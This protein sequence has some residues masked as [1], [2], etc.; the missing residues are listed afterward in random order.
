[1]KFILTRH[2]ETDWNREGR[3]QG[4]SDTHLNE[5]GWFQ[6]EELAEK[7]KGFEIKKI[8]SSDLKR[9]I[10]TSSM[11][12]KYLNV[13]VQTDPRIRECA[14]GK[15]EG[16]TKEEAS[17]A[18]YGS[19]IHYNFEQFGGE[20]RDR[21]LRRHLSLLTDIRQ[22]ESMDP[23]LLVGHGTG[24]NTLLNHLGKPPISRGEF[25]EIEYSK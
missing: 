25:A 6:A 16:S 18:G 19:L 15:L 17:I 22:K 7:L 9:S 21:V 14:Y 5:Y 10:E 3:L 11:L 13:P 24:F 2:C 4:H 20:S 23:I 1:M 12:S 8:I